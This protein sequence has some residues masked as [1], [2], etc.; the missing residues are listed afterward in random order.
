MNSM[1]AYYVLSY[2]SLD[3]DSAAM[4]MLDAPGSR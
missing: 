3:Y 4:I 2:P 1:S